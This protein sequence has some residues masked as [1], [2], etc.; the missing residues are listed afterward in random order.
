[1]GGAS[2]QINQQNTGISHPINPIA[3]T[4]QKDNAT[5]PTKKIKS[6]QY[7]LHVVTHIYAQS[8]MDTHF[9]EQLR[10]FADFDMYIQR[11]IDM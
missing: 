4:I 10:I 2:I 5:A 9:Y 8:H 1:M 11:N 6:T 7:F 3:K